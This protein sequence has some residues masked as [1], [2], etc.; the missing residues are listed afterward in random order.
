MMSSKTE[1]F[2]D[3]IE[4]AKNRIIGKRFGRLIVTGYVP[5]SRKPKCEA[6]A[7]CKCDCGNTSITQVGGLRSGHTQSCGC[8]L[9]ETTKKRMTTHGKHNTSEYKTWQ[10]LRNRCYYKNNINYNDYGGR[11]IIVCASW[12]DEEY[13]FLNFFRDM[14]KRPSKNHSIDRINND[15]N[16]EPSNCRWATAKEQANNKRPTKCN[17]KY[18]PRDDKGRFTKEVS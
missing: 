2:K 3:R 16:Y 15:G 4:K 12:L 18:K 11:G 9:A 5:G 17:N 6:R 7:I 8:F 14:G 13:G 10:N 1:H